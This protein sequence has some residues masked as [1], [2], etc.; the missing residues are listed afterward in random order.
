MKIYKHW[1]VEKQKVLIDGAEQPITCYGGSN[2]SME[3]ARSRAKEKA[4]KI[5]RKIREKSISSMSAKSKGGR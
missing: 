4:E 3:D 5:K 2:I 1:A